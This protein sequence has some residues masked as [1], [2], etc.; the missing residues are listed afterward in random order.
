MVAASLATLQ[1]TR[2]AELSGFYYRDYSKCLPDY[3]SRLARSAYERRAGELALLTNTA[4]IAKRQAWARQSFWTITGGEPER[5]PLNSRTTGRFERDGYLLEKVVYESRPGVFVTANLYVPKTGKPP[6]PATLFQM[7]HS[8]LGKA[9]APYQK[10][11][12]SLARLGYVV[13][14]FDPMGQGERIGYPDESGVN[15]KLE[16]IDEEHSIPGRQ[17]MLLGDTASR[18][19]VWDAIRS[20]DYLA[21]HSLV[22][23][24]RLASVGQSGGATVTMMLGCVDDRLSAAA[25]SSGNTEDV[26]VPAFNAP[27]S[28]D[29]A[30]QD[31]IGSGLIGFDRC[32]L[33]Y[34]MAPK[35]LLLQV[36]SHDFFGTYSP[37]YLEESRREYQKLA[38][39]YGVLG[40][41]ESL[42]WKST[43]LPHG[44]TY[45]LRLEIYNFFERRLKKSDKHIESEPAVTLDEPKVL[46]AGASG[47]VARDFGSLR[48]FD[49]IKR[50]AANLRRNEEHGAWRR[51]LR[52]E[53][54]AT[55]LRLRQLASSKLKGTRVIATEV[56]TSREIWIPA[57]LFLPDK[58]DPNSRALIVLNDR[59][60]NAEELEDGAYHRLASNG[61]IVLAADVRGIGDTRPEVGRGNPGY[62]ISHDSEEDFAWAS[63]I[64]GEPM[65]A[66][67]IND[68]LALTRALKNEPEAARHPITL[69][70][71]GRL[72]VPSLFAFAASTDLESLYLSGGLVSFQNLLETEQYKE[73]LANFSWDLYRYVDLP[74]VAA[75]ATPRR[76]HLAG[77]VDATGTVMATDAVKRIYNSANVTISEAAP[78]D[79]Q[80]LGTA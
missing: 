66:G 37:E 61:Q 57:W 69:A 58:P 45:E 25:V 43:P 35:P 80:S 77:A 38:A 48:P 36:S 46:W 42:E 22:D 9:Y 75:E 31:F 33:L 72:S 15:T 63:L 47:N 10:C 3:V 18:Y 56:N 76:V 78:W 51:M 12:Q 2:A 21:G 71:R 60:R 39:V 28:T 5:S 74:A 16:S 59:G 6:Y 19:Q 40:K 32:D 4:A 17:M 7:G 65:L 79:E 73:T 23:P 30:E 70:A 20:L 54:P 11:C 67:R 24:Q 62:T 34:P 68:V 55:G 27:G 41:P 52:L 64:L 53:Q 50:S 44:L 8:G 1:R 49:S 26:A 14:A 29:D 13:L